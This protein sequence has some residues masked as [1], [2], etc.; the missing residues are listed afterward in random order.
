MTKNKALVV[1]ILATFVV[2]AAAIAVPGVFGSSPAS[3][4]FGLQFTRTGG[5]A[6]ANDV[7]TVSQSGDV[8]YTSRFSTGFNATLSRD[9]LSTLEDSLVTNLGAIQSSVFSPKEGAADFFSY[10]LSVAVN[11]KTT[12]LSWVDEWASLGA[13]PTELR[14]VQQMLQNTIQSLMPVAA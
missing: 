13:F 1:A 9:E 12:Q 7:L 3:T 11:G 8:S 10:H 4:S 2:A 14:N 5:L 6:G